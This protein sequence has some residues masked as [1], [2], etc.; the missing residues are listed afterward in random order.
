MMWQRSTLPQ[1]R[2]WEQ[3]IAYCTDLRLAGVSDWRLPSVGELQSIVDCG[4]FGPAID[5]AFGSLSSVYWSSTT[6]AAFPDRAWFVHFDD[7]L[8]SGGAG[9]D[10]NDYVRAVR[11]AP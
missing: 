5:P 10:G 11:D 3:A 1:G 9:K 8:V 2:S 6:Y 7:G 4:R